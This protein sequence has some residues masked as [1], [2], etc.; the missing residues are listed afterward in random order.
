MTLH[1]DISDE[2]PNQSDDFMPTSIVGYVRLSK[3]RK[4]GL[5]LEVQKAAIRTYAESVGLPVIAIYE[6]VVSGADKG[7][8]EFNK[9]INHVKRLRGS[10]LVVKTLCRLARKAS[11][12]LTVVDEIPVVVADNP[13]MS[14]MELGIR[15]LVDQEERTRVSQRTK[16]TIA[17]LKTQGRTFGTPGNLT[18]E[19]RSKGHEA[20]RTKSVEDNA[21]ITD[22]IMF[23]HESGISLRQIAKTLNDRGLKTINGANFQ[24]VTVKRIIERFVRCTN[25]D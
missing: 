23:M 8:V 20:R 18:P 25:G 17:Y 15:A 13:N 11:T 1:G 14:S 12:T 5:S 7:R 2:V 6:E 19:A 22:R 3:N 24:P 4:N 9:A 16:A 21:S 10:I